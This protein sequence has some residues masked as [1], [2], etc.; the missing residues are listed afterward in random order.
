MLWKILVPDEKGLTLW[1][2]KVRTLAGGLTVVARTEGHW[3]SPFGETFVEPMWLVRIACDE[4][5][6]E[7]VADLTANMF[8]QQAVM[9]YLVSDR[10]RL[11]H[12]EKEKD[13]V[14]YV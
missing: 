9:F 13:Y 14:T 7:E 4:E 8:H 5:T 2:N 6:I 3:V 1:K 11:K 10:V 12:Y